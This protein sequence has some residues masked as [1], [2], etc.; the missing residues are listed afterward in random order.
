MAKHPPK[1]HLMKDLKDKFY[2]NAKELGM[3]FIFMAWLSYS[4]FALGFNILNTSSSIQCINHIS[5]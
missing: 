1:N 2:A 4:V 3:G 5:K